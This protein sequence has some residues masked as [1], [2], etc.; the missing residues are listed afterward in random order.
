MTRD[1]E[2]VRLRAMFVAF[3]MLAWDGHDLRRRAWD[4]RWAALDE[5]AA[6][7]F[8]TLQ[9][10]PRRCMVPLVMVMA[11]PRSLGAPPR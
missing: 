2:S 11:R 7:C 9:L 6:G 8:A 5:V 3:D 10:S 1:V 4:K